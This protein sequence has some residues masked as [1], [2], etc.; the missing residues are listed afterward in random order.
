MEPGRANSRP[1][2]MCPS[3]PPGWLRPKRPRRASPRGGN[4]SPSTPARSS[5]VVQPANAIA[6]TCHLDVKVE[7]GLLDINFGDWHGLT[8]AEARQRWPEQVTASYEYPEKVS[9]PNGETL[10]QVRRRAMAAITNICKLHE[11]FEIVLV[12]HTVVNRLIVLAVLAASNRRFWHPAQD[13]VRHQ[14]HRS[15][16]D[17]FTLV[18]MNDTCHLT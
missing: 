10:E 15:E 4:R 7:P 5:P 11:D 9:I 3:T 16:N 8:P 2:R 17:D 12:S 13:F 14:R 6:Q 18:S 1:G